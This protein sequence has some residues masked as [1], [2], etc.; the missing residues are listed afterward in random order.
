MAS[1][2]SITSSRR[3]RSHSSESSSSQRGRDIFR[4]LGTLKG[5]WPR[6]RVAALARGPEDPLELRERNAESPGERS[7]LFGKRRRTVTGWAQRGLDGAEAASF[8][9]A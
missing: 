5:V 3:V 6:V 1:R 8:V 9:S 2:R 4:A 7:A